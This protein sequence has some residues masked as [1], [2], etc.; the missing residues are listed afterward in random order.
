MS[1]S[2]TA[3]VTGHS[4]NTI[5]R[6]LELASTAAKRFNHRMSR[7]FDLVEL[8]AD[9]LRTFIGSK[10]NIIWLF[11]TIEV[12]SRLWAGS[13]LGRRSDRNARVIITNV[14]R[15]GRVAG[16]PLIATNGFDYYLGAV[17]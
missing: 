3:R 10:R 14:V 8:Q 1:I 4:R 11:A 12:S 13:I 5:A 7:G 6:W 17:A 16:C 15:R 2:A 9:E